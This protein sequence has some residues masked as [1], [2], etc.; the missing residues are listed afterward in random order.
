MRTTI[1]RHTLAL[2]ATL[3]AALA[4]PLGAQSYPTDDPVIRRI[5]DEGMT[6]KSQ[7][8]RLAQVLMD[9]IGPRL[10]GSPA[11]LSATDWVSSV[12]A[13]AM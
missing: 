10:S 4:A 12:S 3:G 1:S 7:V 2:A 9:S 6:G 8:G 5:W 13:S 11:F